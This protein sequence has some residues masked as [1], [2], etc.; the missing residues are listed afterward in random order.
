MWRHTIFKV[1]SIKL[2]KELGLRGFKFFG[3]EPNRKVPWYN[4]YLFEDTPELR[5]AITEINK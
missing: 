1:F 3:T 4:V 5:K 2:A